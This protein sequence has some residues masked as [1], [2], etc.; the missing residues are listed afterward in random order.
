[1]SDIVLYAN[2]YDISATGFYFSSAEQFEEKFARHLPVEEYEIDFIEGSA[3]DAALF[4]AMRVGQGQLEQYFDDIVPLADW[5]KAALY[6][7]FAIYSPGMDWHIALRRVEDEVRVRQG[8]AKEY[9]ED[10]ID[11]IGGVGELGRAA[12]DM[13]FDYVAFGRDLKFD[14]D[15]DE[16]GDEYYLSLSDQE[17]GEEY[18]DSMGGVKELGQ[19]AERYFDVDAFARDAEL[20][21]DITEFD[22]AGDTY[23]T[24]Y[25]G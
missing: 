13:Y 24:D 18:V 7:L 8:N 9:V 23:V 12:G 16:P 14:L 6:Y 2:P 25:R 5:E 22:F 11:D 15:P 20:N 10:Y 21:G 19:V 3:E 4:E 1:M 17:R